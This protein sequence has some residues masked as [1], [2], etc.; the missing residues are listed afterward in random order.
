MLGRATIT[1]GIGPHSS[2][3]LECR[4]EMCCSRLAVNRGRKKVAKNRYLGT[5]AQ[6]RRA[7]YS[8]LRHISTIGKKSLSSNMS[9]RCPHNMVNFGQLAAEIVSLVWGTLAN[10]S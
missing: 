5:I 10:F 4:S 6:L 7:I 9:S 2:A 3:N 8:Q 1:L